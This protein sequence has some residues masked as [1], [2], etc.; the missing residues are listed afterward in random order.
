MKKQSVSRYVYLP[1]SEM[2][3]QVG[4]P[5]PQSSMKKGLYL[6]VFEG[7]ECSSMIISGSKEVI[8]EASVTG[9]R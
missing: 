9:W 7:G 6:E 1:M 2:E 5:F 4:G 3:L 8:G